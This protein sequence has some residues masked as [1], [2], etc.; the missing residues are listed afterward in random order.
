MTL[1]GAVVWDGVWCCVGEAKRMMNDVAFPSPHH[2]RHRAAPA[3]TNA[4]QAPASQAASKVK[5]G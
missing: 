4:R 5:D 2:V 3:I 1:Q